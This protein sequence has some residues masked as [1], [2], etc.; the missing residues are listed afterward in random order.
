VQGN[1]A[2][3]R[4]SQNGLTPE[5]TPYRSLSGEDIEF[6]SHVGSPFVGSDIMTSQRLAM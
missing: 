4:K 2:K 6:G 3:R 5:L 1:A